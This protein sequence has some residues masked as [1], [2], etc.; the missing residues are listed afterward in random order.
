[1]VSRANDAHSPPTGTIDG[2]MMPKLRAEAS[3]GKAAR[4]ISSVL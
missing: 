1:M 3:V 2:A 4:S